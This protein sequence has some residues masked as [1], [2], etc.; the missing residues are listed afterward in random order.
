[1]ED[2]DQHRRRRRRRLR[3]SQRPLKRL[4][5]RA[6][7]RQQRAP[8]AQVVRCLDRV[9]RGVTTNCRLR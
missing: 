9:A 5:T 1:L 3:Q 6:V 8:V 4:T 2:R 7:A